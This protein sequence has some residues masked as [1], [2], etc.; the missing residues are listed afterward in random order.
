M[1]GYPHHFKIVQTVQ[2]KARMMPL[3]ILGFG[4]VQVIL[5]L[6]SCHCITGDKFC[7]PAIVAIDTASINGMNID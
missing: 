7:L 1:H 5:E 3:V 6:I 2:C 4:A